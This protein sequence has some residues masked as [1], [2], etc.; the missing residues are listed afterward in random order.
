MKLR[1]D[2]L[3][4]I[5]LEHAETPHQLPRDTTCRLNQIPATQNSRAIF[6]LSPTGRRDGPSSN[7]H[8]LFLR[9]LSAAASLSILGRLLVRWGSGFASAGCGVRPLIHPSMLMADPLLYR[10]RRSRN[11][12]RFHHGSQRAASPLAHQ[13]KGVLP[14]KLRRTLGQAV[15]ARDGT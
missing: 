6:Y 14:T 10:A 5:T 1:A 4:E 12:I 15:P 3:V 2:A 8:G 9:A 13:S 11:R 7:L